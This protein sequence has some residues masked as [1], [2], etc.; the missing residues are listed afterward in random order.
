GTVLCLRRQIFPAALKY[1]TTCCD[2]VLLTTIL[3]VADGP[4]SPLVVGYFLVIVG[5]ALRLQLRLVWCATI[6]SMAG[7][8]FL[9]GYARW[10]A[11]ESRDL[12]VPRYQ[13]L[14]MLVALAMTGIILGQVVRRVRAMAEEFAERLAA[15]RQA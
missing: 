8:L 3:T 6:G 5:S 14:I 11:P 13:Q 9:L 1:F 2:V 15:S 4:R 7:Y 12:T 10:F